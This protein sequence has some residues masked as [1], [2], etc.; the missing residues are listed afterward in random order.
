MNRPAPVIVALAIGA[1]FWPAIVS[2]Q[3]TLVLKNGRRITAQAYR[4]EGQVI[5]IYGIGGEIG[6]PRDQ[7]Q[8]ILRAGEGEGRGLD[9]RG[10][11]GPQGGSSEPSQEDEKSLRQPQEPSAPEEKPADQRAK[12]ERDY[13]QKVQEMTEQIKAARDSYALGSTG[14]SGPEPS[15]FTSEEAF[16]GRQDDLISRLRDAQHNP[17]GPSDAKTPKFLTPSPFSGVPPTTT[18][19]APLVPP[20][21]T[22][23]SPLPGYSDQ[24]KELSD[25]RSQ[26]GQLMM[27]RERLIQEMKDNNFDTGSLFLD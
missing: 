6:I 7:V 16:R 2:A 11:E 22:V 5:K 8:S 20:A 4:E 1:L 26:I 23:N 24:Q 10:A 12:K 27:E 19:I 13:Q 14:S 15:F 25:L 21:P 17:L 18:E 9:L 3:Y